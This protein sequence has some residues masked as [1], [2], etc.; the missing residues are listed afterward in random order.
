LVYSE[1]GRAFGG[2][3]LDA[4]DMFLIVGRLIPEQ[5]GPQRSVFC[6]TIGRE[7]DTGGPKG[8]LQRTIERF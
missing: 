6:A 5:F 1:P 2:A 3:V 8:L 7:I 4:A